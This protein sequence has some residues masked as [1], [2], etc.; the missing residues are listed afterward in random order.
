MHLEDNI[1]GDPAE[2]K[3]R[4]AAQ[5]EWGV[6]QIRR[7]DLSKER[8]LE[9]SHTSLIDGSPFPSFLCRGPNPFA[10]PQPTIYR[11]W[12]SN[13]HWRSRAEDFKSS[14]SA[15][16][17]VV[18]GHSNSHGPNNIEGVGDRS[19]AAIHVLFNSD[20]WTANGNSRSRSGQPAISHRTTSFQRTHL[21]AV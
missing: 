3:R 21:S 2:F 10:S 20:G 1:P 15:M 5:W 9:E 4:S 12:E 16:T 14:A 19:G 13:P 8:R 7:V 17:A 11:R 6:E 18:D